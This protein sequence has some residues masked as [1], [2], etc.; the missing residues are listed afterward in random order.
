MKGAGAMLRRAAASLE[1]KAPE[2]PLPG[3]VMKLTAIGRD[4]FIDFDLELDPKMVPFQRSSM[5]QD[6]RTRLGDVEAAIRAA[7]RA[8]AAARSRPVAGRRQPGPPRRRRPRHGPGRVD[9]VPRRPHEAF[10]ALARAIPDRRA[11][12]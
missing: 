1:S 10:V 2:K 9:R 8:A 6:I 12:K 7:R 3:K 5:L 11:K 4:T